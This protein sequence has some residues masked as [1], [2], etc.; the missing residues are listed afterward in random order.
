M[1]FLMSTG[2]TALTGIAPVAAVTAAPA[3]SSVLVVSRGAFLTLIN[4]VLLVGISL[5]DLIIRSMLV[6]IVML[7][8]TICEPLNSHHAPN[9]GKVMHT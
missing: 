8:Y 3:V 9:I 5:R 6:N 4:H 7:L 2:D 1:T